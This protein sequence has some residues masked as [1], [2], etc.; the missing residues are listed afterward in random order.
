LSYELS[1]YEVITRAAVGTVLTSALNESLIEKVPNA[2]TLLGGSG[3]NT[4]V[5]LS[6]RAPT[7]DGG[8]TF[9]IHGYIIQISTNSGTSWVTQVANTASTTPYFVVSS[10]TNGTSYQFRVAA[11]NEEGTG[12]YSAATQNIIPA[13]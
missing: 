6:W 10:L 12:A 9:A 4:T 1:L 8:S 13:A 3:G 5:A 11:L 7:Y 2:P